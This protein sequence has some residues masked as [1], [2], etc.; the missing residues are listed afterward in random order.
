MKERQNTPTRNLEKGQKKSYP[1]GSLFFI[2][3]IRSGFITRLDSSDQEI[4]HS[5]S[6][7]RLGDLLV[8][9]DEKTESKSQTRSRSFWQRNQ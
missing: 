3:I 1:M 7:N 5:F 9:F 2:P 6:H 8:A 4:A